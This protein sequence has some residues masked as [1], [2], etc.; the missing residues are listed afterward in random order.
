M[1]VMRL[2]LVTA[3]LCLTVISTLAA[4]AYAW[5]GSNP[6]QYT[7]RYPY[8]YQYQYYNRQP[9]PY[10]YQ[11]PNQNQYNYPSSNQYPNQNPYI[12][13]GQPPLRPYY[14]VYAVP[15]LTTAYGDFTRCQQ[16]A[17][18][19][20]NCFVPDASNSPNLGS[21]QMEP[22]IQIWGN[23]STGQTMNQ[24]KYQCSKTGAGWFPL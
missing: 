3:A 1:K 9:H 23:C 17:L 16:Y 10:Q 6:Y 7:Y 11:F 22:G 18:H 13:P 21:I 19:Q 20:A 8:P 24:S 12:A 15:S 14:S 4:P 2:V 5:G